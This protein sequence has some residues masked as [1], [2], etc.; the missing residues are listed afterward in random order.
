MIGLG[1]YSSSRYASSSS[2]RTFPRIPAASS[3]RATLLNLVLNAAQ[4]LQG[5]GTVTVVMAPASGGMVQ[6]QVRDTGIGIAESEVSRLFQN[7][8]QASAA[9]SHK[10][11]GTGLGL[12]LSQKLCTL[13]GGTITV[14]SEI[15]HGS[16]FSFCVPASL[17]VS[18]SA[19]EQWD[20][21]SLVSP[22]LAGVA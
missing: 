1:R 5:S 17:S 8:G 11:G 18:R 21:A 9:T 6:V 19:E 22:A 10:Y 4:A 20:G 3:M 12:A 14:N 7:F 13:M 2:L 16:V 15:G